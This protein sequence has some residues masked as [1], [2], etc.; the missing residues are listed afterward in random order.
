MGF[1]KDKYAKWGQASLRA[2]GP[3]ARH[4]SET[5]EIEAWLLGGYPGG[6][7][8]IDQDFPDISYG[9]H[10]KK[11]TNPVRAAFFIS[12]AKISN[13]SREHYNSTELTTIKQQLKELDV[14]LLESKLRN[15]MAAKREHAKW[16]CA[17]GTWFI[18]VALAAANIFLEDKKINRHDY[19]FFV[20]EIFGAIASQPTKLEGIFYSEQ[21]KGLSFG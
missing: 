5:R 3:R 1:L 16:Q 21:S 6:L 15:S 12:V 2:M 19:D 11:N 4:W 9:Y 10:Y 13:F 17:A 18:A 20:S 8:Q 14:K 7:K